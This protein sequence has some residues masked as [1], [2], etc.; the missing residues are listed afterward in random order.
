MKAKLLILVV[1]YFLL[2]I[3][4]VSCGACNDVKYYDFH[5][6]DILTDSP[7]VSVTDSLL[8]RIRPNDTIYRANENSLNGVF[9]S[10][11]AF[12]CDDGWGGMKYRVLKIEITSDRDFSDD[13]PANALLNNIVTAN[14]LIGGGNHFYQNFSAIDLQTDLWSDMYIV[15]KPTREKAHRL[16][17]TIYKENGET[18]SAESDEIVWE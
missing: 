7:T 18:V 4:L 5:A 8:F 16:K 11:Y 9:N 3:I 14:T 2:N 15:K 12:D 17:V 10:A 1:G 6:M 13:Y